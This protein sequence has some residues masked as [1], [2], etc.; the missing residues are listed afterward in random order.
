MR[1]AIS[2]N[3]RG[4]LAVGGHGHDRAAVV[5]PLAQAGAA[6]GSGRAAARPARRPA[7]GPRRRR[8]SRS[9]LPSSP[10]NHDM[11]SM[12]PFTSRFTFSAIAADRRATF[13]AAGCG[14]VTTYTSARGR[15]CDSER[16]MSPVPGGMSIEQE[17][18]VVPVHV[19]E[20]LLERLV[21]HRAPPDHR[22]ALGHEVA[23][24]DAAHAPLLG[25]QQHLVDDDGVT[26]GAEH[27]RDREA[28]DVGV[29]ARRPSGPAWARATARFVVTE[30]LAHAA[31]A[32]G[33]EQRPGL[34][35]RLGERDGPALGVTVGGPGR[36][37]A[38]AAGSPWRRW[39]S[40]SRSSSVMTV[41]S[42]PTALDAVEG[43]DGGGD[44]VGDLGAQRAA[45]HREGH[46]HVDPAARR[47]RR[48]APCRDRR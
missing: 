41:K 28:V 36:W 6:A 18:G 2:R 1:W 25:R 23:H 42:R 3:D 15:Y 35:A 43:G 47:C 11:F 26:V 16:A 12:T 40:A 44:P 38:V 46:E 37:P 29:D 34:G 33:D 19:G 17:V 4:R 14:V 22:L 21:Q 8:R 27:A 30:L 20:E 9:G 31:L 39:R 10:V 24:G 45:G 48:R 13:W 32:R 5:A 7:P